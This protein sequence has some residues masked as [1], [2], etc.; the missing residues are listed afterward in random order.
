MKKWTADRLMQNAIKVCPFAWS[1][2]MSAE[3]HMDWLTTCFLQKQPL[4][5]CFAV[6]H[7]KS[8]GAKF[9]SLSK[10]LL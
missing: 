9:V 1:P 5:T 4:T 10:N 6:K 7:R 3:R 2:G 8:E